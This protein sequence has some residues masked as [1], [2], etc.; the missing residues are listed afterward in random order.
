LRPFHGYKRANESRKKAKKGF[1]YRLQITSFLFHFSKKW[2]K[3]SKS[4]SV[5][6]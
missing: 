2:N 6:K 5:C 1:L 4:L 3:T